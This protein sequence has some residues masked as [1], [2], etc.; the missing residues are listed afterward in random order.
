M[1][2]VKIACVNKF[3][4][5]RNMAV[6]II[7]LIACNCNRMIQPATAINFGST[8]NSKDRRQNNIRI[9]SLIVYMTKLSGFKRFRIQSS[10]T[11]FRIQ[12]LRRH[13]QNREFLFR[14]RPL[15]CKW[16]N[17]SGTKTI[18]IR[19]ESGTISSS[20][21]LVLNTRLQ[22]RVVIFLRYELS[23]KKILGW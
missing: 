15:V 7:K 1:A 2:D 4:F 3:R 6:H 16:Q 22:F 5:L 12:N 11:K 9:R 21:N 13:D 14:N 10:H 18:R 17:E 8:A 23:R 19:H 20:V